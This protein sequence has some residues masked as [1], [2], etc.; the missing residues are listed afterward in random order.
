MN[1]GSDGDAPAQQEQLT[2]VP[3]QQSTFGQTD[4]N[5][6]EQEFEEADDQDKYSDKTLFTQLKLTL[7]LTKALVMTLH[8]RLNVTT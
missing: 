5:E 8:H 3:A 1:S 6:Q 4:S 7:Q 2:Y